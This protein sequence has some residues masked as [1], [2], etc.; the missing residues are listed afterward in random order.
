MSKAYALLFF[1]FLGACTA[2]HSKQ[3]APQEW[4]APNVVIVFADDLGYGDLGCTGGP[5]RTP[6]IDRL[7]DEGAFFQDFAVAQPVCSASRAALLT[8]CYPS[9]LGIQ[10]A[11]GPH[12]KHGLD[13]SEV[14]LA[15]LLKAE[16]YRTA[17]YGKWHLGV[18][19]ELL[20]TRQGFD[21]FVGIP[22]SNDMWPHHPETASYPALHLYRQDEIVEEVTDQSDFTL[23]FSR[24]GADFIRRSHEAGEPFF[25]YLPQPMPHVPLFVSKEFEGHSG[26]GLY[27]DVVEEIDAGVGII[28]ETLEELGLADDTLVI[29][30]SD[31]GPWLSYGDHAGTTGGFREGKGTVF[32]GGVRE[33]MVARWPRGI[34]AGTVVE[35]ACM[36]IDLLPSIATLTGATL[37]HHALD[38]RD[39]TPLLTGATETLAPEHLYFYWYRS[40]ELHAMRMGRWKLHFPHGYRSMH[41]R[42]PG[43]GGIPGKYDYSVKTGLELYDLHQDPAEIIDLAAVH[44]EIVTRMTS[45]ADVMRVRLGDRIQEIEGSEVRGPWRAE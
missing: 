21:E 42:E 32:E 35:E 12:D 10:G 29:F 9:R 5:Y 39:I 14:T 43:K 37:P 4:K 17:I 1:L 23:G 36:T 16:G 30:T 31:N 19:P 24:M 6:N 33:P 28:L 25:L 2:P 40:N 34:P 45:M 41:G 20:P 7:A 18:L 22:Y 44:P 27:G 3:D 38:G 8:G 26:K 15:D 13:P 11:L